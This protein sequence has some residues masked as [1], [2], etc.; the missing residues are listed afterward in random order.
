MRS[1][2]VLRARFT[3]ERLRD[4]L[5][6]GISHYVILGAGFDTFTLRHPSW[7]RSLQIVEIDHRRLQVEKRELAEIAGLPFCGNS[8]LVAIDLEHDLLRDKLKAH[9]RSPCSPT[10]FSLLGVTMYLHDD[11]VNRVLH[12]LA[13]FPPGSEVVV[14]FASPLST[15]ARSLDRFDEPWLSFYHPNEFLDK[16]YRAGFSHAGLLSPM[17]AMERYFRHSSVD[18]PP[19]Q[20]TN[21]AY[22]IR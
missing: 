17:E 5:D 21:I 15:A 4:S 11:A 12:A 14:T 19:P 9:L 13:S 6:R 16:L 18:L 22:A 2:V 10:F 7:S 20:R 1:H 8:S 3:E